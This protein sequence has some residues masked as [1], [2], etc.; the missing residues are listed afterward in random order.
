M[1]ALPKKP[2]IPA[3]IFSSRPMARVGD[4]HAHAR[5]NPQSIKGSLTWHG[6]GMHKYER[7]LNWVNCPT[8]FPASSSEAEFRRS[9]P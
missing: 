3:D 8:F 6:A 5:R 9:L 4:T 2:C 1:L 7:T